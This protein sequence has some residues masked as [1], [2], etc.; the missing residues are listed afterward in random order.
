MWMWLAMV[1]NGMVLTVVVVAIYVI[2]LMEFCH[3]DSKEATKATSLEMLAFVK[4][5]L[6]LKYQNVLKCSLP[7][8]YT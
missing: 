1:M 8:T 3:S 7:G 5:S 4:Y 2:S 6:I